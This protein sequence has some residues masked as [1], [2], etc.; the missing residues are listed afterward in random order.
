VSGY[1]LLNYCGKQRRALCLS[2]DEKFLNRSVQT[3]P[4]QNNMLFGNT[5][6]GQA[7]PLM[8]MINSRSEIN[9][10]RDSHG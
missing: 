1:K 9:F 5:S 4:D 8:M 7:T 10:A 3:F 2:G 6:A